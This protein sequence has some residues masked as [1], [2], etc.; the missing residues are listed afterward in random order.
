MLRLCYQTI[1]KTSHRV[2]FGPTNHL[3]IVQPLRSKNLVESP[4]R[5]LT[6]LENPRQ[7][8]R[9]KTTQVLLEPQ[10][11]LLLRSELPLPKGT[12]HRLTAG[13][14]LRMSWWTRNAAAFVWCLT[15]A[16]L[17]G[18]IG[19][20]SKAFPKAQKWL[21]SAYSLHIRD[22]GNLVC[23]HFKKLIICVKI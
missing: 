12:H 13:P 4:Q 15:P 6:L 2:A 1:M 8:A 20:P 10:V 23:K 5:K 19:W 14:L 18:E 11:M 17:W 9:C 7:S 16:Q 22:V 21:K 3:S